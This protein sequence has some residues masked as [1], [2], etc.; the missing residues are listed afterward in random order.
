MSNFDHRKARRKKQQRVS[1]TRQ[2][3]KRFA[4]RQVTPEIRRVDNIL[5]AVGRTLRRSASRLV[6][7]IEE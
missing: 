1:H 2:P 5:K 4:R 7:P 3:K 6:F